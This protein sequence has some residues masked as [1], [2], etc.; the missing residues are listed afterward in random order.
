M[1]KLSDMCR[2]SLVALTLSRVAFC[3]ALFA[4]RNLSTLRRP[5][6]K[7]QEVPGE[8]AIGLALKHAI[9]EMIVPLPAT[10]ASPRHAAA[11]LPVAIE[12]ETWTQKTCQC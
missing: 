3:K 11:Q 5:K 4:V 10:P 9:I 6:Q 12:S 2:G 1:M 7:N 8:K